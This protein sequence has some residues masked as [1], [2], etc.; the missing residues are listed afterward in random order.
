L[1]RRIRDYDAHPRKRELAAIV[2][3]AE[4][5]ERF[6]RAYAATAREYAP[7]ITATINNAGI[8]T[9]LYT[10][11]TLYHEAYETARTLR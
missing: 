4:A 5:S 6:Y 1:T 11:D 10:L 8:D 3:E 7:V 9:G 2:H